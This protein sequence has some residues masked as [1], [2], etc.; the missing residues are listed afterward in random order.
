GDGEAGAVGIE[1]TIAADGFGI[2][3][4]GGDAHL[5]LDAMRGADLAQE[6]LVGL[7]RHARSASFVERI[8]RRWA[9]WELLRNQAGGATLV[10]AK[11]ARSPP[12]PEFSP[13]ATI[14]ANGPRPG[15]AIPCS[16]IRLTA[17]ACGR[18]CNSHSASMP[19]IPMAMRD[20]TALAGFI[21]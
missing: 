11:P 8:S 21:W 7:R 18:C 1:R 12:C 6:D 2:L 4:V 10:Q 15:A 19:S 17:P 5:A 3:G 14:S 13:I 16:W 20:P 9:A